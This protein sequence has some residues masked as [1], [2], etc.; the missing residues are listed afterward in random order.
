ML[1][2]TRSRYKESVKA[3]DLEK[4]NRLIDTELIPALETIAG[5]RSAQAYNS[6]AGEVTFVLDMEDMATIDRILADPGLKPVMG[7]VLYEWMVRVGGEVLYDRP[8]WQGL[9][10]EG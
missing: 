6:I 1:Y 4:V 3:G 2:I 9:Y 7:R 10:G 5:V 8:V